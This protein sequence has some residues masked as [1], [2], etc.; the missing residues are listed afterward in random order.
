MRSIY[1]L[2]AGFLLLSAPAGAQIYF[3]GEVGVNVSS[4]TGKQSGTNRKMRVGETFGF[5]M[6]K[7][8]TWHL[9]LVSGLTYARNGYTL[10]RDGLIYK[11]GINTLEIPLNLEC[12]IGRPKKVNYFIG[13]GPYVAANL[14]GKTAL[15]GLFPTNQ[16]LRVGY[17][18]GDDIRRYD[19]G[20]DL[21]FVVQ[22]TKGL[23]FRARCNSSFFNLDPS[24]YAREN[25]MR[26]Q[27]LRI[28]VGYM[29]E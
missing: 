20:F 12:E 27:D 22:P 17:G 8:I 24:K 3:G 10:N 16:D 11:V 29:F 25:A 19:A 1:F 6:S 2:L 28:T 21:W 14:G 7:D 15:S 23:F 9:S 18:A 26:N 5:I 13:G 4:Y